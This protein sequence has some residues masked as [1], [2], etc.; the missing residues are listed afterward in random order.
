MNKL[1]KWVA[2]GLSF[3][4]VAGAAAQAWPNKPVK[5]IAVFPPGGSVDTVARILSFQLSKQTGQQFVVDNKG[6]ASGSIGTALVA[7]SPA[8][9]YTFAVVFDTHGVNPSLI[10]NLPFDTLK[11]LAPVMIVGTSPMVIAKFHGAPYKDFRE[12]IALGKAKSDAVSFGTIGSGSLGHL[13]MTQIANLAGTTFNHIP[14]KGGGPLVQD[15]IAGHVPLMIGTV[16]LAKPQID[17]KLLTP[18]AVTSAKRS[19][20]LPDTPT[21][22]EQGVPGFESVAWWG[23]VAPAGTPPAVITRMNEELVKVLK[24]PEV[25]EKLAAQGMDVVGSK[26]EALQSFLQ[27]EITRWAKVV[28]DNKI[29]AGE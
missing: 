5:V 22:A 28:K 24:T 10:P 29:K 11:D 8:D 26:P 19:P 17:A 15:A 6:G 13:A 27:D 20:K 18:L 1:F 16:F 25:A 7:K 4:Y 3:L 23:V 14:Y 12:L 2:L 21:V 9:G